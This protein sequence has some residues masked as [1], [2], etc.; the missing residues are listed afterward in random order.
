MKC[1][2]VSPLDLCPRDIGIGVKN[3]FPLSRVDTMGGVNKV[4]VRLDNEP[5]PTRQ[6]AIGARLLSYFE[7]KHFVTRNKY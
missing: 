4:Y 5:V 7:N 1:L 6:R 2:F 3:Y